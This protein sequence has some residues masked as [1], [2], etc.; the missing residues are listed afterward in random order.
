M[1]T[2]PPKGL[3][4]FTEARATTTT[5]SFPEDRSATPLSAARD[6]D[7]EEA[8]VQ[9]HQLHG[10]GAWLGCGVYGVRVLVGYECGR[11]RWVNMKHLDLA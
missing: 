5:R 11:L 10:R 7:A 1:L 4:R 3:Q 6:I 8:P 9:E 2:G